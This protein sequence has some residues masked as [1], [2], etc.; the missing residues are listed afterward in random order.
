MESREVRGGV[1][2]SVFDQRGWQ[3]V[4]WGGV[5]R[6]CWG[7]ICKTLSQRVTELGVCFKEFLRREYIYVQMA[8]N[9]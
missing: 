3:R 9:S 7:A 8:I 4:G 1:R 5:V 6:P 2:K